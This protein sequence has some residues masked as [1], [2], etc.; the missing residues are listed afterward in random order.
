[1]AVAFDLEI[2]I[3]LYR[4]VPKLV[5]CETRRETTLVT[6]AASFKNSTFPDEFSDEIFMRTE[7]HNLAR[8][9]ADLRGRERAGT[10]A[11]SLWFANW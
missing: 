6:Q 1:M 4:A 11:G 7:I 8:R 2:G 3:G 10:Q 5:S 9:K